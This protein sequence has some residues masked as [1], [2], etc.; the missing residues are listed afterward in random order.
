MPIYFA[1]FTTA[2]L[3]VGGD[4]SNQNLPQSG[5]LLYCVIIGFINIYPAGL[6]G[7]I[8]PLLKLRQQFRCSGRRKA[9]QGRTGHGRGN[10]ARC[11]GSS[12]VWG[13][14]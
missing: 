14:C 4:A 1:W 7:D 13:R 5:R 11:P 12:G 3:S 6:S 10:R 2:L 8:S 9:A